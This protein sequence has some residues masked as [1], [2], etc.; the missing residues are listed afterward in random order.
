MRTRRESVRYWA[1]AK[2]EYES[3]WTSDNNMK[4]RKKRGIYSDLSLAQPFKRPAPV[5][6]S[7][8]VTSVTKRPHLLP[9]LEVNQIDHNS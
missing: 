8:G 6:E 5:T 9:N 1:L 7:P 2:A 3:C 4:E